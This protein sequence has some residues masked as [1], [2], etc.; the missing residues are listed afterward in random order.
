MAESGTRGTQELYLIR[1]APVRS[2]GGAY[3]QRDLPADLSDPEAM[4]ALA[5]ALPQPTRVVVSPAMR[6][7]ETAGTIWP[8]EAPRS[9]PDFLEQSLGDWEGMPMSE[10]PD[11]GALP[12]AALAAHRPPGGESFLDLCARV[13]PALERLIASA[14]RQEGPV[15]VV[16]H[17]GTVRAA[18]AH[19]IGDIPAALAF[20]IDTLSVT[21]IT[22]LE[23]GR[24]SVGEVNRCLA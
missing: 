1:H 4:R 10:V 13:S 9:E 3:G 5:R 23:R 6:C 19:A 24:F 18:L 12:R 22:A 7:V 17:G 21:R 20:R 8:K 16:A 14:R 11:L 15:M 2:D